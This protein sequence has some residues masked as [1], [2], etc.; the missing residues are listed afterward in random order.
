MLPPNS[1]RSP[2]ACGQDRR[3]RSYTSSL[4][5]GFDLEF[6]QG[7]LAVVV[8]RLEHLLIFLKH[9]VAPK[10][11]K[12]LLYDI[13]HFVFDLVEHPLIKFTCGKNS[14][15]FEVDKVTGGF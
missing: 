5:D 15:I 10:K 1:F 2:T 9:W 13:G 12:D 11:L 7:E 8:H 14:G 3:K 6:V 4:P